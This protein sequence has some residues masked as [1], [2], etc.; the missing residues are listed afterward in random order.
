M[1]LPR[2]LKTI[3]VHVDLPLDHLRELWPEKLHG[4]RIGALL[5]SASVSSH[6]EHASQILER[7]NGDLLR[8]CA[9]FGPQHGFL[10][11]T[12]DNMVEWQSYEHP[13][14]V[15]RVYS[16]YGDH[17]EPTAEILEHVAALVVDLPAIEARYYAFIWM[18]NIC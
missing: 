16:L 8:L 14:V 2:V 13:R 7:H 15:I 5:H 11:Q 9:F 1:N 10:G 4:A 3:R 17:R 12:Q 18:L 6:L